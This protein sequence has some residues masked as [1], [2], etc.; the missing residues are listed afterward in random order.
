MKRLLAIAGAALVGLTVYFLTRPPA[1]VTIDK[2]A[3]ISKKDAPTST[4]TDPAEVFKRAF[5]RLPA[6]GDKILHAERR[7]WSDDHGVTKWQWF[8]EVEPSE[9]LVKYLRTENSFGLVPV[10]SAGDMKEAP[11]WFA[12]DPIE[13]EV[14]G[15]RGNLRM[16][17]SRTG[18]RLFATDSGG[19]FHPGVPEPTKRPTDPV[20]SG[21]L[22][23]ASSPGSQ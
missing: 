3:I 10:G 14:L 17:F 4:V 16:I 21:R 8:I 19:G 23:S 7:E 18:N 9:K 13:F 12:F 11:G 20:P 5:W 15:S 2:P 6:D 1:N 22:P